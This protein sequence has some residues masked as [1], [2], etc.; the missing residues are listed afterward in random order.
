[1]EKESINSPL[2]E[3]VEEMKSYFTRQIN[4]NKL[5]LSK[6]LSESSAGL[7]FFIVLSGMLALT[8]LS[9]S[10]AFVYWYSFFYGRVY[11]GFLILSAF[12]VVL[13]IVV[14][15]F[16]RQWIFNPLR[17]ATGRLLFTE[18]GSDDDDELKTGIFKS[19]ESLDDAIEKANDELEKHEEELKVLFEHVSQQ[20]TLKNITQHLAKNAYSSFLTTTNIAKA[21]FLLI[22]R[23][24]GKKKKRKKLKE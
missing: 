6:R 13:A 23:L 19:D 11:E 20:F 1:M 4:Y 17:K 8:L 3:A 18:D 10:F 24:K 7:L 21:S 16:R 5:L 2:L 15:L 9:L 12:Y 22:S 14:I